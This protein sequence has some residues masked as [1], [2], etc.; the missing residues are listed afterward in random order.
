MKATTVNFTLL[1]SLLLVSAAFIGAMSPN[2]NNGNIEYEE[3]IKTVNFDTSIQQ[4]DP[5]ALDKFTEYEL[6]EKD[7]GILTFTGSMFFDSPA[8]LAEPMKNDNNKGMKEKGNKVNVKMKIDS[9]KA[10]IEGTA[11]LYQENELLEVASFIAWSIP[12]DILFTVD[13]ITYSVSE[14]QAL[15]GVE[16][17]AFFLLV[18]PLAAAIA[19]ALAAA[20]PVLIVVTVAV[21]VIYVGALIVIELV[22]R[23]N[24]GS[25]KTISKIEYDENKLTFKIN[26]TTYNMKAIQDSS[27]QSGKYYFASIK[28]GNVYMAPIALTTE[29]AKTIMRTSDSRIGVYTMVGNDAYNLARISAN[30]SDTVIGPENHIN[31]GVK[32]YTYFDHY[33]RDRTS[34]THA[35]FGLGQKK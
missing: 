15:G 9:K 23:Y 18:I 10:T 20:A 7:D 4:A 35:F 6:L 17:C 12:G 22:E 25:E 1:V 24:D 21:I 30:P 34:H 3:Y 13:G 33:H 8:F 28:G 16:N 31:N 19:A 32:G 11:E 29:E 2:I 27:R 14:I 26:G 5:S